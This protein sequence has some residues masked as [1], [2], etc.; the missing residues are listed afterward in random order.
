MCGLCLPHCPTYAVSQTESESPRGR[1]S[2]IKAY[3][4]GQLSSS[5]GLEQHLQSCTGC[6]SCQRVCPAK[7]EFDDII[8]AGRAAYR[9]NLSISTRLMQN[10]TNKA[11]TSDQGHRF[12]Q[13][14]SRLAQRFPVINKSRAGHLLKLVQQKNKVRHIS[15]ASKTMIF[16]GCTA[17]LF[18]QT[19]LRSLAFLM[20]KFGVE[21]H[22]PTETLCC[23]ALAQ[24]SG[25]PEKALQH[26]SKIT[27]YCEEHNIEQCISFASGCARELTK[28]SSSR[29]VQH[30][31]V[32]QW[33]LSQ[34]EFTQLKAKPLAKRVLVHTACSMSAQA[35]LAMRTI[36]A[37]IPEL[38]LI[39]FNDGIN[40][41]GAGGMQLITP[42]ESSSRLAL[43]KASRIKE[44]KPEIIVSANIGC[45]MQFRQVLAEEEIE[46]EVIHPIT[47]FARQLKF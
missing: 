28:F 21:P 31:D 8:D 1:I 33:L 43:Q 42:N 12:I 14:S 29:P 6:F 30:I 13:K 10:I 7:V 26:R 47:L 3:L 34:S 5:D 39:E 22:I 9:K 16:S 46:T 45:A 36:L 32:H 18:D 37:T 40:C 25:L 11:L 35:V 27:A 19:T 38:N 17:D 4:E 41:C 23:G 44:L 20:R 15:P 24:H 2:L